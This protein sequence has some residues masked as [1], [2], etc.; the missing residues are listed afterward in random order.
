[1]QEN[2]STVPNS[3]IDEGVIKSLHEDWNRKIAADAKYWLENDA[4]IRAITDAKSYEEFCDIVKTA[5]LKPISR[6]EFSEMRGKKERKEYFAMANTSAQT[7]QPHFSEETSADVKNSTE[8]V[9]QWNKLDYRGRGVLLKKLDS[10]KLHLFLQVET[11]PGM[12]GDLTKIIEYTPELET[13]MRK[14]L[15]SMVSSKRFSLNLLFL[16]EDELE[17]YSNVLDALGND[18]VV[19]HLKE[20]FG[21]I[22][23][24]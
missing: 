7:L 2:Q 11:P 8:F 3:I 22:K 12:L 15:Q 16:N 5:H 13:W 18:D 1:M 23:Q 24:Q 9:A 14:L 19:L 10:D 6:K 17:F 4:K 20:R 21:L